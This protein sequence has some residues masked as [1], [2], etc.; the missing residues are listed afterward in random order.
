MTSADVPAVAAIEQ[1][2]YSYPWTEGIFA[3]CLKVK[4]ECWVLCENRV[5]SAYGMMSVAA[6]EAHIL[7]LCVAVAAQHHGRGKRLLK[8]LQNIA[9][10]KGVDT[11][12]LEVRPSNGVALALYQK[13]GFNELGLRK[14]YYPGE[15]KREDALILAKAL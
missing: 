8:H 15:N 12:F 7:N 14:D 3:D 11:L 2:A 9:M 4:Y 10:K 1:Q 13:L 5:I 6:G